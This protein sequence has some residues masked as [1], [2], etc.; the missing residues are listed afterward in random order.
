MYL[1]KAMILRLFPHFNFCTH[2]NPFSPLPSSTLCHL[3][4][5]L[6]LFSVW[7]WG[8]RKGW[9]MLEGREWRHCA[10]RSGKVREAQCHSQSHCSDRPATWQS[11]LTEPEEPQSGTQWITDG[12]IWAEN[13]HN[14]TQKH[15]FKVAL[16]SIF[17]EEKICEERRKKIKHCVFS[18][19]NR[20][21]NTYKR[22]GR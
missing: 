17:E 22:E 5:S 4:L 21:R 3:F 1:T 7:H 8:L 16:F 12:G 15:S 10:Q 13:L 2:V 9:G 14:K 18:Y 19:W 6:P 11:R 20:D